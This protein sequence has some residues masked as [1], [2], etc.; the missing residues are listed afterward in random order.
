MARSAISQEWSLGPDRAL[1][2]GWRSFRE[3]VFELQQV[4]PELDPE[5]GRRHERGRGDEPRELIDQHRAK[6][7]PAAFSW[8]CAILGRALM[9]A[10]SR[11]SLRGFL[12]DEVQRHGHGTC[13]SAGRSSTPM[14]AGCGPRRTSL[15]APYFSSP[16]PGRQAVTNSFRPAPPAGPDQRPVT[17]SIR[18]WSGDGGN[19]VWHRGEEP[20][21]R[22][23]ASFDRSEGARWSSSQDPRRSRTAA[24]SMQTGDRPHRVSGFTE[25][26]K[27]QNA[28]SENAADHL[29]LAD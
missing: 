26:M 1:R 5:R 14:G 28:T 16:C 19:L 20:N 15:A 7:R 12:H 27:Q 9:P 13:R 17:A 11:A 24:Q 10:T 6:P 23:Q 21:A 18:G 2:R 3:I 4:D 8:P 25:V 22:S 29:D